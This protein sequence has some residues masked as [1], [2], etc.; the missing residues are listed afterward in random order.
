M[1]QENEGTHHAD[2]DRNQLNHRTHRGHAS[3][4]SNKGALPLQYMTQKNVFG[5]PGRRR[6]LAAPCDRLAAGQSYSQSSPAIQA[7][8]RPS[9]SLTKSKGR[10]TVERHRGSRSFRIGVAPS[11]DSVRCT[12][13]RPVIGPY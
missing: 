7:A 4:R 9:A 6:N 2:S 8:S 5:T 13:R 1:R 11:R 3:P 12:D 10:P